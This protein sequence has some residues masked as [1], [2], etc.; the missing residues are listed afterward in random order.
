MPPTDLQTKIG[1]LIVNLVPQLA[2]LQTQ[3]FAARGRFWQG[4]MT[5]AVIPADGIASSP[6]PD[7]RPADETT[8][9]RTLGVS[10][11]AQTEA[12]F[13]V[14]AYVGPQGPGYAIHVHVIASGVR[15]LRVINSGP[16]TWRTH[17]WT[18]LK[19]AI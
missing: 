4:R 13:S 15:Y 6:N 7:A 16:E 11:P 10:F 8:S 14:E 12:A 17:N 2:P 5:H 1:A 19:A 3:H 18:A 9:R